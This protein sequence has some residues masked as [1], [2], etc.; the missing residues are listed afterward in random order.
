MSWLGTMMGLPLAGD[1]MLLGKHQHPGLDLGFDRQ[2]HV[3]RHLV[4]VESR[5]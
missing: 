1:R 2:R 3:H 5:R 4:A